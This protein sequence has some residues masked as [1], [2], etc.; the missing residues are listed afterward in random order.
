[1]TLGTQTQPQGKLLDYEQFIDHQLQRTRKRIK[2]TDITTACLTLVVGFLGVLFLEVVFDHVFGM[3]LWLREI[4]L[5]SGVALIAVYSA[6]RIVTPLVSRINALYAA[7]TIE[8]AEPAFKNSLINYLELRRTRGQMPKAVLATLETRAVNDLTLVDVEAAVNQ[9]RMTHAAYALTGVIVVFALY[10]AFA[11]KNPVDSI[12]RAFLADI[13]RPTNTRLAN[14]KPG[15]NPELAKRVAGSLVTFEVDVQGMRPEKVLL[16]HSNDGGKFFA[17]KEFSPGKNEYDPWQFTMPNVQQSMEYYLTG[18]DAESPHYRLDV[19]EAPTVT[20]IS[21]DLL[22][23]AYTKIPPRMGDEGGQIEAIEGTEVVIYAKTNM[24]VRTAVINL[25]Y[26]AGSADMEVSRDDSTE[27]VGKFKVTKSGTYKIDFRTTGNQV[28]PSPVNYDIFAL[29][30]RE[31]TVKFIQPSQ[32]NV[33]VPSNVKVDLTA[34]GTDDHGVRDATLYVRLGNEDLMGSGENLLENQE[35]RPEFRVTKTLDLAKLHVKPGDLISYWL[36]VRD[37]KDPVPHRVDTQHQVIEVTAP[38]TPEEQK[39]LEREQKKQSEQ[40]NPGPPDKPDNLAPG[41]QAPETPPPADQPQTAPPTPTE[42]TP[43]SDG[44]NRPAENEGPN[45]TQPGDTNP[46]QG[47]PRD[48][49]GEFTPQEMKKI[50]QTLKDLDRQKTQAG[51]GNTKGNN[52]PGANQPGGNPSNNG[53]IPSNPKE[54]QAQRNQEQPSNGTNRGGTNP[55]PQQP[56]TSGQPTNVPNPQDNTNRGDG[57]QVQQGSREGAQPPQANPESNTKPNTG[58]QQKA[59]SEPVTPGQAGPQS[60]AGTN[61]NQPQGG[62]NPNQPRGAQ[63][64]GS[65]PQGSQPQGS[66]PQGTQP[67]G[68]QPQGSQP[69][70]SQ[71]QGSQPQGSHPHGS[72]PQGSQPQG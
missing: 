6:F 70:G 36:T 38:A 28:N 67:Q 62:T 20:A 50:D 72:Q 33:K 14:I 44:Q 35:P 71:P 10:W 55:A 37:N 21:H 52:A 49:Q 56:G 68:S 25:S 53:T 29:P 16:H 61:P 12:R 27:L 15:D 54:A 18:G 4:I 34:T 65:Q 31:P 64:Q 17:I 39:R 57:T 11:P 66:Q 41:E 63:P 30:D 7:K 8:G 40:L 13:A 60:P 19:L 45:A 59:G 47:P 46:Q 32:P 1:M 51:Q 69:Q 42:P 24:P 26:S 5:F 58:R 9:Q 3:P 22:F 2:F 48:D 43:P 23:P